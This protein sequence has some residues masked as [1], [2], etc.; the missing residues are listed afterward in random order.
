MDYPQ[1]KCGTCDYQAQ[2]ELYRSRLRHQLVLDI[3]NTH[4]IHGPSLGEVGEYYGYDFFTGQAAIFVLKL[5]P[6]NASPAE[7]SQGLYTA[8][9]FLRN[10]LETCEGEHELCCTEDFLA[11]LLSISKDTEDWKRMLAMCFQRLRRDDQ[12]A[13]FHLILGVGPVASD[14][15]SLCEG[16]RAAMNALELGVMYGYDRVYDCTALDEILPLDSAVLSSLHQ[17][18]LQDLLTAR[19]PEQLKTWLETLFSE[20]SPIFEIHPV[21]A[22]R[23]PREIMQRA[24]TIVWGLPGAEVFRQGNLLDS[25][26]TLSQEQEALTELFR[27]FCL[28]GS[29]SLSAAVSLVQSH[30]ALHFREALTLEQLSTLSGLNPQYL[31]TIYRQE[32]GRTVT[33]HIKSLRVLAA[34]FLLR[35]TQLSVEQIAHQLGYEDFRYFSRVF[36]KATGKTPSGYR[37]GL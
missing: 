6:K 22:F 2:A 29:S 37:K 36:Q 17:A 31:S 7:R 4:P 11:G 32:T 34:Q 33:Q 15:D 5:S 3:V 30:I 19:D 10:T 18:V 13:P 28:A 12:L 14:A 25:C 27:R 1:E 26:V 20:M 21:Q 16:F 24:H 23:L 9:K 35:D 8:E